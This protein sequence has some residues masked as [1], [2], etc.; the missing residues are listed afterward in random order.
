MVW[1][2]SGQHA[3]HIACT[4]RVRSWTNELA[5][6]AASTPAPLLP[7]LRSRVCAAFR[8][9]ISDPAFLRA[10]HVVM[11]ALGTGATPFIGVADAVAVARVSRLR[12]R[13]RINTFNAGDGEA[14]M[15]VNPDEIGMESAESTSEFESN[16]STTT[17][18]DR[19]SS[20]DSVDDD[21]HAPQMSFCHRSERHVVVGRVAAVDDAAVLVSSV[22]DCAKLWQAESDRARIPVEVRLVSRTV[23]TLLSDSV[24]RTSDGR[25]ELFDVSLSERLRANIVL[26]LV[27]AASGR[28]LLS[29]VKPA[30]AYEAGRQIDLV[31]RTLFVDWHLLDV[32]AG[33]RLILRTLS[34]SVAEV[35]ASDVYAD[36]RGGARVDLSGA[37]AALGSLLTLC[38]HDPVQVRQARTVRTTVGGVS[39]ATTVTTQLPWAE[40]KAVCG[41]GDD[42]VIVDVVI[43]GETLVT[44]GVATAVCSKRDGVVSIDIGA[45]H[46]RAVAGA[47]VELRLSRN[48]VARVARPL[49]SARELIVHDLTPHFKRRLLDTQWSRD[50]WVADERVGCTIASVRALPDRSASARL[51]FARQAPQLSVGDNVALHTI[52]A[53]GQLVA[54]G[55]SRLRNGL[56]THIDRKAFWRVVNQRV[57]AAATS[58]RNGSVHVG[59]CGAR[60]ALAQLYQIIDQARAK[61]GRRIEVFAEVFG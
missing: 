55:A 41:D 17:S 19:S 5:H 45:P 3:F 38:A 25:M 46:A 40:W 29:G 23:C 47:A 51:R 16:D 20:D 30:S 11:V 61:H 44:A 34:R 18:S 9:E 43:E 1:S 14:L 13:I 12:A 26:E 53:Y 54:I 59:F 24:G 49:T 50:L 21:D 37:V 8:S 22:T 57:V 42:D 2:R 48:V 31:V 28:V 27:E 58:T 32:P 7:R 52:G 33:V 10:P 35:L 6:V 4:S 56:C 15:R 39:N 60:V 36:E